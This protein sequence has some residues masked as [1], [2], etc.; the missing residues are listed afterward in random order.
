MEQKTYIELIENLAECSKLLLKSQIAIDDGDIAQS[1][2]LFLNV[3]D[4]MSTL[5]KDTFVEVYEMCG[6]NNEKVDYDI[7]SLNLAQL[8]C[9]GVKLATTLLDISLDGNTNP[10]KTAL[11]EKLVST[12]N[13]I[14]ELY[15][16][17]FN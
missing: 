1:Q 15:E 12:L 17:L 10:A 9:D 16:Q 3:K 11:C 4:I 7:S 5:V 2:K 6:N 8:M 13:S 14:T